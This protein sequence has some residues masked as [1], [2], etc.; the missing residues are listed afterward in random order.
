MFLPQVAA[1]YIGP[2]AGFAVLTSGAVLLLAIAASGVVLHLAFYDISA[3][4]FAAAARGGANGPAGGHSRLGWTRSWSRSNIRQKGFSLVF[5]RLAAEGGY[6]RLATT[7]PFSSPAAPHFKPASIP[8]LMAVSSFLALD[9]AAY[10]PILSGLRTSPAARALRFGRYRLPLGRPEQEL[11]R[12]S[13][14]FWHI[15]AERGI[16][17]LILRVPVCPP[18]PFRGHILSGMSV[19]DLR[20]TQGSFFVYC[21]SAEHFAEQRR[22]QSAPAG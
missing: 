9:R 12:G 13:H 14:P 20:G 11:L 5:A 8:A 17:L 18:E 21:S 2:G 6:S 4:V 19:P 22:L 15:L 7:A 3:V 16:F 1:A 10:L